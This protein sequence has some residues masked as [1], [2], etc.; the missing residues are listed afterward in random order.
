MNFDNDYRAAGFD[1]FLSRSVD[2]TPQANLDSQG[3]ISNSVPFDRTQVSGPVGDTIQVGG[4]KLDSK[5]NSL[6]LNDATFYIN[7]QNTG[8][9]IQGSS[10]NITYYDEQGNLV[11]QEGILPN[12]ATGIRMVD[13]NN[14]GIA[15]FGRNKDGSTT[16]KIAKSGYEVSTALD[17]Q[18]IFNSAQDIFKIVQ[19]GT[20]NFTSPKANTSTTQALPHGLSYIPICIAFLRNGNNGQISFTGSRMLPCH[21]QLFVDNTSTI[22]VQFRDWLS[23]TTDATNINFTYYNAQAGP[24]AFDV[25]L[26]IDYYILQETASN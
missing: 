18:L 26:T 3:P 25:T 21:I 5:E 8:T 15:Q 22:S 6:T 17:T 16:L 19:T 23:V 2:Q 11:V 9:S 1:D 14:I 20:V 12:G 10:G 4:M 7:D 24:G 13:K